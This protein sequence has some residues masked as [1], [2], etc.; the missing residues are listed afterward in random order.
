VT[1]GLV[2]VDFLAAGAG[3]VLIKW[4]LVVDAQG[5]LVDFDGDNLPGVAQSDL[6]ALADD[7]GCRRG[8]TR[9]VALG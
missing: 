2:S 8:R 7:F 3:N 9:C 5:G 6:D 1:V 4:S